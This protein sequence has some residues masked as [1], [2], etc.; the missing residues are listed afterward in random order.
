MFKKMGIAA[1]ICLTAVGAYWLGSAGTLRTAINH[2]PPAAPA[3]TT[4]TLPQDITPA[5]ATAV[6]RAASLMLKNDGEGALDVLK[7]LDSVKDKTPHDEWE[8]NK[9][10]TYA[11][12]RISR[13]DIA[14]QAA[15]ALV[16]SPVEPKDGKRDD[17]QW[18][19]ISAY[20]NR[21]LAG[22]VHY[23]L[24]AQREGVLSPLAAQTAL[25]AANDISPKDGADFARRTGQPAPP[26]VATE[27]PSTR[28]GNSV[29]EAAAQRGPSAQ[30]NDSGMNTQTAQRQSSSG[31]SN[32]IVVANAGTKTSDGA[33]SAGFPSANDPEFK[34]RAPVLTLIHVFQGVPQ[35]D[36]VNWLN[37]FK[38]LARDKYLHNE[39]LA[40]N[41]P[42]GSPGSAEYKN[43]CSVSIEYGY[44][45][46]H[47]AN[48]D[49]PRVQMGA[50]VPGERRTMPESLPSLQVFMMNH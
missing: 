17:Y 12:G 13:F 9:V 22:A 15:E 29:A 26:R 32:T 50:F 37:D 48:P 42:G 38:S 30:A 39:C 25:R 31:A 10:K 16:N 8:I 7:P 27:Q 47:P 2:N 40:L 45:F 49:T 35:L 43:V 18:A 46:P 36:N 23:A 6:R 1:A 28:A 5:V 41:G 11:A 20:R 4:E 34:H 33:P 3:R 14:E 19:V 24:Q 44:V 21:N